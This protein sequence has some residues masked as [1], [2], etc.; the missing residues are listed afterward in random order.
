M[1]KHFCAR[2]TRIGIVEP[3]Y[4]APCVDMNGNPLAGYSSPANCGTEI[5]NANYVSVLAPYDLTRGGSS[6]Y[7]HGH[8]D[9]KETGPLYRGSDQGGQLELQPGHSR[10]Q[11]QRLDRAAS[12]AEPRVGI[13]Y[14]IKPSG[15]VLQRVLCAHAGDAVQR[16]PGVVEQRLRKCGAVAPL[17]NCTTGVW[18]RSNRASAMSFTQVSSRRLAK[19]AVVSG[20]YIWKYTHNAFDFSV[21]GNT[22]IT[23]PIDWHNSKIPGFAIRAAVPGNHDFSAFF[24]TSRWLRGSPPQVAGAGATVAQGVH[25]HSASITTKSSTRPRMCSTRLQR[26]TSW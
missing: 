5:A 16:K 21:L 2:A 12:Q 6:Y 24:D 1:G 4:N 20:E 22:P 23:F 14:N 19:H 10:R 17:L 11:V 26:A 7:F 8:T 13:A 25:I 15:T 18:E 3:T 9:V